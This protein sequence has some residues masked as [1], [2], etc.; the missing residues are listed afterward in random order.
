MQ[1][2]EHIMATMIKLS[3][4]TNNLKSLSLEENLALIKEAELRW[5]SGDSGY[6]QDILNDI[7]SENINKIQR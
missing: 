7:Y 5:K 2:Y 1:A 4:N 6:Y 3:K